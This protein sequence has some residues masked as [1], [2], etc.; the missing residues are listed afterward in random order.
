[1]LTHFIYINRTSQTST[2]FSKYLSYIIKISS[3][4]VAM[5]FY[6]WVSSN[7]KQDVT[8]YFKHTGNVTVLSIEDGFH[9]YPDCIY[10][11]DIL[12]KDGVIPEAQIKDVLSLL[13]TNIYGGLFLD[14]TTE[15]SD[16][17][18]LMDK[19]ANSLNPLFVSISYNRSDNWFF[20]TPKKHPHLVEYIAIELKHAILTYERR[21]YFREP[22]YELAPMA[23][24]KDFVKEHQ[25]I[26]P[27]K[28]TIPFI[29]P[30]PGVWISEEYGIK[31]YCTKSW[32]K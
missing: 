7:L 8:L 5:P 25:N 2:E 1:M 17:K 30:E 15:V 13:I 28:F 23:Y 24:F 21:Q 14:C 27:S 16:L 32:K 11:Y 19:C 29:L 4:N 31:K 9:E 12:M 3:E 26:E 18:K 6:L 22:P 20:Y 10:F